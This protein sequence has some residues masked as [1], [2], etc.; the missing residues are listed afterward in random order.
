MVSFCF[1]SID[2]IETGY[3]SYVIEKTG[4]LDTHAVGSGFTP[5]SELVQ[6]LN[7]LLRVSESQLS[8][9]QVRVHE[10]LFVSGQQE[11]LR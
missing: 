5:R 6:K 2:R 9:R 7:V 11:K 10:R 1:V 3:A 8:P 4:L